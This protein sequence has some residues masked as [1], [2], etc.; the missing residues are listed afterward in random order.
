[1]KRCLALLLALLLF[2]GCQ[3]MYPDE[4]VSVNEHVAPFAYRETAAATTVTEPDPL[5]AMTRV[6]RASDIREAIQD[7]VIH[8]EQTGE[9]LLQDYAGSVEQDMKD[10]FNTLLSDSPKY[11]YAMDSFDWNL[12]NS[13]AGVIV[14]VQMQL[15]L[16]PQEIQA[17]ET[18]IFPEPALS[19][20]YKALRQQISSF[21]VQVSGYQETD[22]TQLL[23]EYILHHPDQIAEAPGIS[24]AVY[25]DRGNVRV[26]EL[27]FVYDTDR[28]TLRIHKE[29]TDAFLNLVVSQLSAAKSPRELVETIYK[30]LVPGIGY[31]S[32]EDATVYSQTVRKIGSSRTMA[33]VVEYLC[34]KA[35]W[36]CAIVRGERDGESW[37]W[38]RLETEE[39][40][41]YFDLHAAALTSEPPELLAAEDL[42]NYDW[43]RELYPEKEPPEPED[44]TEP[45][46]PDEETEPTEPSEPTEQTEPSEPAE[47]ETQPG[48]TETQLPETP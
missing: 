26:V 10:M 25:P 2:A 5:A 3:R 48:P 13:D 42:E 14:Q 38:N 47:T 44:T 40:W 22:F 35:G 39:Q 1:M 16:T 46:G 41:L 6:S 34:L 36:N 30:H 9:F 4:Y 23:E 37:Y 43:D 28:D 17:I 7:L 20:V 45:A 8:G 33:S 15:R 27:H 29:E 31:E 21:T 18:R 19:D 32:A 12:Q 24:A 11:T